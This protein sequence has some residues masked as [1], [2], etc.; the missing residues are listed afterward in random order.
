[1]VTTLSLSSTASTSTYGHSVPVEAQVTPDTAT[2]AVQFSVDG[3]PVGNPV[4]VAN[5]KADYSITGLAAG[6]DTVTASYSGGFAPSSATLTGGLTVSKA[7]LTVAPDATSSV[8]GQSAPAFADAVTGYQYSD[9]AGSMTTAPSCSAPATTTAVGNYTIS[10]TAGTAANYTFDTSATATY[11]VTPATLT[12]APANQTSVYGHA[13]P[14]FTA[15]I[16]GFQYADDASSLTSQPTCAPPTPSTDVAGYTISCSPGSAA[17]YTFDTS[18]T[19]TY[20]VTPA[21]LTVS[22]DHQTSVYGQPVPPFTDTITGFQYGEDSPVLGIQPTCTPPNPSTAVGNYTITCTPGTAA[23]YT[24]DT[25]ATATY[26]VTKATLFVTPDHQTKVYGQSDPAFTYSVTGYQYGEG[27]SGLATQPSC[28]TI[29]AHPV[30]VGSYAIHC[31]GGTAV[32]Y[33]FN[34]QATS[35]L[36]IT[37]ATLSVTPDNQ[38]KVFATSDPLFSYSITGYQHGDDSTALSA[39]PS[40]APTGSHVDVGRYTIA[41]APGTAG[42][43]LFDTSATS[44]LAVTPAPLEVTVTGRGVL[45]GTPNFSYAQ[46]SDLPSGVTSVTGTLAGCVSSKTQSTTPGVYGSTISSCTGLSV[47]GPQRGNYVIAYG[48]GAFTLTA[49]RP[50]WQVAADGG[51]FSFGDAGFYGSAGNIHL[52]QPVVG[53]AATP[54]GKGYWL[55]ASDGGLFAYGDAAFYG[56]T[57]DIHLNAPIVTTLATPDGQGYWLVASDGGVFT[58]GD[59]AFYGAP[60]GHLTSP[61]VSAQASSDGHGYWLIASNGSTYTFGDATSAGSPTGPLNA[62]IVGSA[63][64]HTR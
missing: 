19:A 46:P 3:T 38:S 57:G 48:S 16:T 35:Q 1:M 9:T 27:S 40:C 53:M 2:G 37:P 30:D 28:S 24:F 31:T 41:C 56:S 36:S 50:Y 61:V 51:V 12:V 44:T 29:A 60:V 11:S 49:S 6:I 21:T 34:T 14:A 23:N 64:P 17:N 59:A 8:Y 5:G 42:N 55:V 32:D 45:G 13:A 39:Q 54:D 20:T 25:S 43:Y 15:S 52:N 47:N 26:S 22:P 62:P 10:C 7:T 18:A 58:Y 63:V 4:P 33:A